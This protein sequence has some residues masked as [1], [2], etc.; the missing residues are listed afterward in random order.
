[1]F[2]EPK[3]G[4]IRYANEQIFFERLEARLFWIQRLSPARRDSL[5][6]SFLVVVSNLIL[7][8]DNILFNPIFHSM[9][10]YLSR[11]VSKY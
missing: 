1:M 3:Y 7:T 6:L 8:F 5:F 9:F 4:D 2:V 10:K 11:R